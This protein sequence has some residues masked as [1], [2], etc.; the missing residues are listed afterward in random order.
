MGRRPP[1]VLERIAPA[2]AMH[3]APGFSSHWSPPALPCK[4]RRSS[5]APQ[6]PRTA[7][8]SAAAPCRWASNR[9]APC[10][11]RRG[12]HCRLPWGRFSSVTAAM[13]EHIMLSCHLL[14][15]RPQKDRRAHVR[16]HAH[17][18]DRLHARRNACMG[19]H[20]RTSI[21]SHVV[22]RGAVGHSREKSCTDPISHGRHPSHVTSKTARARAHARP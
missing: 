1:D 4:T 13:L 19:A 20:M 18:H 7:C 8:R 22:A 3:S 12:S 9:S 16:A 10:W 2:P 14:A 11:R 5:L 6:A 17:M 15:E 21:G